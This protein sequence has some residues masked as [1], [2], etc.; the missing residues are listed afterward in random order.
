M[1]FDLHNGYFAIMPVS[2]GIGGIF[3]S[4]DQSSR[5]SGRKMSD[6]RHELTDPGVNHVGN[7]RNHGRGIHRDRVAGNRGRRFESPTINLQFS[8]TPPKNP[9]G[10]K[11]I[12]LINALIAGSTKS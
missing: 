1:V 2:V 12:F 3:A 5:I 4:F 7:H 9:T 6:E 11:V 10:T 8:E